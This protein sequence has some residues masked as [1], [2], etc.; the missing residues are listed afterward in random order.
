MTVAVSERLFRDPWAHSFTS[1]SPT[2]SAR[3]LPRETLDQI[4]KPLDHANR[5]QDQLNG[6]AAVA[7]ANGRSAPSM[8]W[9]YL[10][11]PEGGKRV[12]HDD[13]SKREEAQITQDV[14]AKLANAR[15]TIP[16]VSTAR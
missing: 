16:K 15:H 2:E 13:R 11:L 6:T 5:D 8:R 14:G 9:S 10:M 7:N 4:D 12:I 3:A 1:P